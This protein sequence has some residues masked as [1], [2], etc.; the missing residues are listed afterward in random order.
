EQVSKKQQEKRAHKELASKRALKDQ[1]TESKSE[2]N[3]GSSLVES[4]N[5]STNEADEPQ[6]TR[7]QANSK[8]L[9]SVATL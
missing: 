3:A 2:S 4:Y 9:L 1:L 6:T 5:I 7:A 8:S